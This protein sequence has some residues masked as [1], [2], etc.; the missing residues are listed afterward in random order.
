MNHYF[1]V[2]KD[3]KKQSFAHEMQ[4]DLEDL[5]RIKK[6][7]KVIQLD[8]KLRT[9]TQGD[10]DVSTCCTCLNSIADMLDNIDSS[11]PERILVMQSM[12]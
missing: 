8:N 5:F 12:G 7:A 6:D 10:S 4:Q 3:L 9:V 1:R 2:H 11:M